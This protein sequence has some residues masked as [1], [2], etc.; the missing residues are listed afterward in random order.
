MKRYLYGNKMFIADLILTSI[1][2]LFMNRCCEWEVLIVLFLIRISLCF[3]MEKKSPW[4]VVSAIGFFLA[5]VCTGCFSMPFKRIIY[6]FCC[7]IGESDFIIHNFSQPL[8]GQMQFCINTLT[9]LGFLWL[10]VM[11]AL[12]GL[13]LKNYREIYWKRKWLWVYTLPL[14]SLCVWVMFTEGIVG[15]FMLGIVI[16]FLP[17]V[18][19]CIYKRNGR[20]PVQLLLSDRKIRWYIFYLV[21]MLSAI[22]V[23]L[24]DIQSFK[25]I[26]LL[27]FPALFYIMLTF[28]L[29]LGTLLTRYCIALS[30]AGLLF[31]L[32]LFN[33]KTAS[34]IFLIVAVA[35]I[36]YVGVIMMTKY[37]QR[38]AGLTLVIVVPLFLIPFIVGF[39]P[40]I[41]LDSDYTRIYASNLSARQG[42]YVV[43]R[44]ANIEEDTTGIWNRRYGLRD[45]Y[46]LI[47]PMDYKE[48]KVIDRQGRFIAVNKPVG[49]ACFRWNHRYGVY[50][51]KE[52]KYIVN[53]DN[54]EIMEIVRINDRSFKLI[55]TDERHFSTL[56]LWYTSKEEYYDTAYF[57]PH[58][59]DE[60]I[61]VEE[62]L[63]LAADIDLKQEGYYSD[64]IRDD[65]LP[66]YKLFLQLVA[67][68]TEESSPVSDM[69][70]AKAVS[71]LISRDPHYK[72]NIINAL[73][74][75]ESLTESFTDSGSPFDFNTW[76][77][78]VRLKSSIMTSLAYDQLMSS[79]PDNE[80]I[81]RE[82]VAWHNLIEV[83]AYYL[84]YISTSDLY[85]VITDKRS[86]FIKEWLDARREAIA[87]EHD[88]IISNQSYSVSPEKSVCLKTESDFN[89]FFWNFHS[90]YNPYYYN[91]MWNEIKT[92]FDKWIFARIKISDE[93]EP[94]QSLSYQ[95]YSREFVN[96]MF[97]FI[98]AMDLPEFRPA[99]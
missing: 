23:G 28:S 39:N 10:A 41:V 60:E 19:W 93:L 12:A 90:T 21:F 87:K 75:V 34:V 97:S 16:S 70:Y 18:Y 58:F 9:T 25:P 82:Y 22:T 86:L 27:V 57:E 44:N 49:D 11:P 38:L 26:G 4:T 29:R 14:T 66:A 43:E 13:R 99:L 47:L 30:V 91:P 40:Y 35:L 46:G 73:N 63:E 45:R 56:Y 85:H 54:V 71:E 68:S 77:D 88:I 48:L 96:E 24:K 20:S 7:A 31:W 62:F 51:L 33:E 3:E 42:V 74:D 50:D 64:L 79:V 61:S 17:V 98:E 89:E 65:N 92:A 83:M 94:Q 37:K 80:W 15:G 52:R 36:I 2:A 1:W 53:P 59:A 95:E 55:D 76:E 69:N 6:L 72:G 32:T 84:D 8:G 5:Y 67:L 78:V 81:E